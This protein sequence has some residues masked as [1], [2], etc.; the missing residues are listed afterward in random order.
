MIPKSIQL[1]TDHLRKNYPI[2]LKGG[3]ELLASTNLNVE[4][5][6]VVAESKYF[7][8]FEYNWKYTLSRWII[9]EDSGK[10]A[11]DD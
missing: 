2:R 3:S 6:E 8:E 7:K 11:L 4:C 5:T 9:Y 1:L 10:L